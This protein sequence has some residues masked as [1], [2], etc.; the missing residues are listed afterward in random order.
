MRLAAAG[1]V[2][3]VLALP[4]PAAADDIGGRMALSCA[5]RL[6]TWLTDQP[7]PS[8]PTFHIG[9]A[10]W[11]MGCAFWLPPTAGPILDTMRAD[12][13]TIDRYREEMAD[14][15]AKSHRAVVC[16][17]WAAIYSST[18][19][20]LIPEYGSDAVA[21][22]PEPETHQTACERWVEGR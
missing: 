20:G 1:V 13:E 16:N 3:L 17:S 7:P 22:L 4:P 11:F 15:A 6:L 10:T 18:Y 2:A 19:L 5:D 8:S 9:L 12:I 14:G 21:G